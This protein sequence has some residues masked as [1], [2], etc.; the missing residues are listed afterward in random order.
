MRHSHFTCSL[1]CIIVAVASALTPTVHAATVTWSAPTNI[2]G[3]SDVIT[4]GSLV[5]ARN[6]SQ[7]QVSPT[8]NGVFFDIFPI[9]NGGNGIS[10]FNNI[11]AFGYNNSESSDTAYGSTSA[12]YNSLSTSYQT[13]LSSGAG[14]SSGNTLTLTL[15]GLTNGTPYLFQW[16]TNDSGLAFGGVNSTTATA[17]NA[18]TLDENTT[19]AVGGMGQWVSGTFTA[20]GTTQVI[21]F[22]GVRPEINAYQ[23]RMVPEP[24]TCVLGIAALAG[25]GFVTRRNKSPS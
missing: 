12:P 16:W 1:R 15:I 9:P 6:F 22:S 21:T 13:L 2:S 10:G 18:V 19:N 7:S 14:S 4:T 23:L 5:D 17:T 24:S 11:V 8:V 3:D 20:S 25:L